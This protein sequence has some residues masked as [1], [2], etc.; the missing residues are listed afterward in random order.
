MNVAI[1]GAHGRV[2]KLIVGKIKEGYLGK[3]T[4]L[5]ILRSEEQKEEP[6]YKGINTSITSLTESVGKLTELL[7]GQDAVIFSAGAGG[8]GLD[9]TFAV[10][11]DGAVK[12]MEASKN[13]GV[14]RFI[15]VSAIAAEDNDFWYDRVPQL[16]SYYIAKK[17]ADR[18]LRRTDLNYTILQ[19]GNL[20]DDGETGSL[21]YNFTTSELSKLQ[22]P[23][24]K[25]FRADVAQ[26]AINIL[27]DDRTYGKTLTLLNGH[28]SF[29][30]YLSD[31]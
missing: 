1:F 30:E 5:A 7:K 27:Q 16:R 20:A 29:G 8:K 4:P 21:A 11:L 31:I 15:M 10:D 25:I 9:K 26:F 3:I 2:G 17:Y 18:E 23:E 24:L 13:A 14:R 12:V 22:F 28:R 6:L 19:P